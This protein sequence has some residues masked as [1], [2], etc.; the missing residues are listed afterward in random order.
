M[1]AEL[2]SY[3]DETFVDTDFGPDIAVAL[4][5]ASGLDWHEDAACKDADPD[6]FYYTD[7][8]RGYDRLMRDNAARAICNRCVVRPECIAA[9]VR[10]NEDYGFWGAS[11]VERASVLKA[12]K[13]KAKREG[14]TPQEQNHFAIAKLLKI[15][16]LP[17]L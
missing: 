2:S 11:E 8:E 9:S 4:S 6:V 17:E 12:A 5:R 16:E 1:T 7:G 3:S 10:R 15:A 13:I 14:L